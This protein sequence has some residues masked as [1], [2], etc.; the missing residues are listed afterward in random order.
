MFEDILLI[1]AALVAAYALNKLFDCFVE[2]ILE[3]FKEEKDSRE[4]AHFR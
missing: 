1:I 3:A 2:A 4:K